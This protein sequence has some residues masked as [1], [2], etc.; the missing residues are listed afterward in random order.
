M[1]VLHD[2]FREKFP[3]VSDQERDACLSAMENLL[4]IEQLEAALTQEKRQTSWHRSEMQRLSGLIPTKP[5][6]DVNG[7]D[8]AN[9]QKR[10]ADDLQSLRVSNNKL[11]K[12]LKIIQ[13]KIAATLAD[14][15]DLEERLEERRSV[16]QANAELRARAEELARE[17]AELAETFRV[18][19]AAM[20]DIQEQLS[21]VNREKQ[22][23]ADFIDAN[24]ATIQ[25]S[26][27]VEDG[28][29]QILRE[30]DEANAPMKEI[31]ARNEEFTQRAE[32]L[33]EKMAG[34][35]AEITELIDLVRSR[36]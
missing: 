11:E 10:V 3:G 20:H 29:M 31:K 7:A 5:V 22:E 1:S 21:T 32:E 33:R 34:Q 16:A 25:E 12:S 14:V 30:L 18:E 4:E 9:Q 35:L 6:E 36:I 13:N 15:R 17:N 8:L 24:E 28:L 26:A 19:N 2:A 27:G 23:I